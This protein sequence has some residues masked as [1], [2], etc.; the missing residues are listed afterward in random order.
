MSIVKDFNLNENVKDN[1]K[2]CLGI[3]ELVLIT[4]NCIYYLNDDESD[5]NACV[6]MCDKNGKQIS[7]NYFAY[8]AL[9]E[10]LEDIIFNNKNYIFTKEGFLEES[11]NY[12]KEI[13]L[14][15]NY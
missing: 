5:E 15:D 8:G 9:I 7:N 3:Y 14:K 10:D 12:L 2:T 11:K 4:E 13:Y 6:I 1:I